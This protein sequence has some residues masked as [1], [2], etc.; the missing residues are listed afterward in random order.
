MN[1]INKIKILALLTPLAVVSCTSKTPVQNHDL[2]VKEGPKAVAT[3]TKD[4]AQAIRTFADG[5]YKVESSISF[6]YTDEKIYEIDEMSSV[7]RAQ[8][9]YQNDA[10]GALLFENHFLNDGGNAYRQYLDL[11][12]TVQKKA[13]TDSTG[14]N[15]VSYAAY[16]GTPFNF[17]T[18]SYSQKVIGD[19]S[20]DTYVKYVNSLFEVKESSADSITLGLTGD[21]EGK[22]TSFFSTFF[23]TKD[24]F[25]WDSVTLKE[26]IKDFSLVLNADG[27][28]K[29][30]TFTHIKQDRFGGI[31]EKYDSTLS[32]I[33]QVSELET[34][35]GTMSA[36]NS[37]KL[38][39]ALTGLKTKLEEGNFTVDINSFDGQLK[40]KSYY[41]LGTT[42]NHLGMMLSDLE[43]T[44]ATRGKTF[45]GVAINS[46]GQYNNIGVSPDAGS[47]D[48]LNNTTYADIA[49]IVP[50]I[51]KLSADFFTTTDGKTFE[52]DLE[53]K[54]WNDYAFSYSLLG[55]L[56]GTA[57]YPSAS[58]GNYLNDSSSY[59]FGF[60][61][62]TLTVSDDG[63]ISPKLD[64]KVSEQSYSSL[65]TYSDFGTTNLQTTSNADFNK[66]V[67][68]VLDSANS[69]TN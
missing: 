41:D 52:M 36:D 45:V 62:L 60:E 33:N 68:I 6:N 14:N 40:Y 28:M 59:T 37:K 31:A 29:S 1:M 35:K 13:I 56:F 22:A 18:T 16:S 66:A 23:A 39:D 10:N 53:N 54:I 57:D 58:E 64:Y 9:I 3:L 8:K 43:L 38:T 51:G 24:S 61:K 50:Q 63:T 7:A 47:T 27:T 25:G 34:I 67:Q 44:D 48:I 11:S 65:V 17:L 42:G 5:S 15:Q 69:S 46:D 4:Q 19:N 2:G 12:N 26:S 55:A 21:G 30:M 32:T 49:S 20:I